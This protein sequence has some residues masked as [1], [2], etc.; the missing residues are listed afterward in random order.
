MKKVTDDDMPDT[1]TSES[2]VS[3]EIKEEDMKASVK[4]MFANG[5]EVIP[6]MVV[7]R[8]PKTRQA[9]RL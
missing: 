4:N 9:Y 7:N 8:D 5:F 6:V 1:E 3:E 2:E